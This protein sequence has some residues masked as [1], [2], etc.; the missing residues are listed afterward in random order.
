M[1]FF[2]KKKRLKY[3]F[4]D[5]NESTD[6][7]HSEKIHWFPHNF[8]EKEKAGGTSRNQIFNDVRCCEKRQKKMKRRARET[9]PSAFAENPPITVDAESW[10]SR[11]SEPF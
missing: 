4:G 7:D 1:Y 10:F 9:A 2:D 8:L 5:E 11:I 3:S 6:F